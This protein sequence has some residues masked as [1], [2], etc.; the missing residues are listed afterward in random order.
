MDVLTA[1]SIKSM[2]HGEQIAHPL[3]PSKANCA[4]HN[5]QQKYSK[6][7]YKILQQVAFLVSTCMGNHKE[8]LS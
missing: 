3:P 6:Y 8:A 4:P 1:P 5:P 7:E 2:L